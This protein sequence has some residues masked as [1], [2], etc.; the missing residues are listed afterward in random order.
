MRKPHAQSKLTA[1]YL[2]QSR[3]TAQRGM[4]H[5]HVALCLMCGT[6]APHLG[7]EILGFQFTNIVNSAA[8]ATWSSVTARLRAAVQDMYYRDLSVDRRIQYVHDYLLAKIGYATQIFPLRPTAYDRLIRQYLRSSDAGK[9]PE[10]LFPPSS[11]G[12]LKGDG[13]WFIHGPRAE[14]FSCPAYKC[15]VSD[16]DHSLLDGWGIGT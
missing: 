6:A 2:G 3:F 14:H 13:A 16:S 7:P 12:R 5:E 11:V 1:T 10:S 9:Y 8:M 15:R 4:P